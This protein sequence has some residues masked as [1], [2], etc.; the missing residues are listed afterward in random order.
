VAFEDVRAGYADFPRDVLSHVTF[1]VPR[2]SKVAI[3][4]QS[5]CGKSTMLLTIMRIVEPR[6]GRILL[7][8]ED[9]QLIGLRTL[10]SAMAVVPQDPVL[11]QGTLRSNIDPF[12]HHSDTNLWRAIRLARLEEVING[13]DGGLNCTIAACGSNLSFGQ[14]QLVSF[15]RILLKEPMLLM[16]DEATSAIDPRSQEAV[17]STLLAWFPESTMLVV[18][19][20][21]QTILMYDL[22][23]IMDKGSVVECRPVN[24]LVYHSQSFRKLKSRLR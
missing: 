14:R 8:G 7:E 12:S 10:R 21:L 4:G 23:I 22:G 1:N 11:M 9:T 6:G 13:L 18:T 16:L 2:R 17:L 19:H 20:R 3:F 24:E 15:A 5:G